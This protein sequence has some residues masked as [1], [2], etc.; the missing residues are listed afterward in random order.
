MKLKTTAQEQ[1]PLQED[2]KIWTFPFTQSYFL[3][4]DVKQRA[5]FFVNY[6]PAL[7]SAFIQSFLSLPTFIEIT[8]TTIQYILL[9]F[10]S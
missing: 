5:I 7:H 1:E 4:C 8:K 2:V 10:S 9:D 6:L 3:K